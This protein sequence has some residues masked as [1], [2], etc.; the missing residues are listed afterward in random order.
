MTDKK[1]RRSQNLPF[2][3][4]SRYQ[5][6]DVNHY[7][8]HDTHNEVGYEALYQLPGQILLR[9]L[10][11]KS[12]SGEAAAISIPQEQLVFCFK[13]AGEN[14]LQAEDVDVRLGP[15]RFLMGYGGD[16]EKI[17]DQADAGQPYQMLM[18]VCPPSVFNDMPFA[19]ENEQLPQS[20]LQATAGKG[21]YVSSYA[22]GTQML[23]AAK[24]LF[25]QKER[26]P[27]NMAFLQA[28][29]TELLCYAIDEIGRQELQEQCKQVSPREL[30]Q[31]REAQDILQ[32]E[33]QTPPTQDELV[34]RLGIGKTRLKNC[35]KA[36]AGCSMSDYLLSLRMQKA[37][38]QLHIGDL[39][40]A[41]IA[42]SI[43]YEHAGNFVA[44]FKRRFGTTPK[45]YQKA[46]QSLG[47]N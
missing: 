14:V 30:E 19:I 20:I 41:Q 32:L 21:R 10:D 24:S 26:G 43:G 28:K 7:I 8:E 29:S 47:P 12:C 37:Q 16:G 23:A 27:W 33:M 38:Q 34:K 45:A 11:L 22:M 36:V 1:E 4:P 13:T 18:L 35:F 46:L 6:R 42:E 25:E 31:I 2:S 40:V 44:A 39:T 3:D 5:Q 9:V 17:T 15:G